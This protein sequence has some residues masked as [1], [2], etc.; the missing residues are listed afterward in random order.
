[1]KIYILPVQPRF[2]L[3]SFG[4]RYP[5]FNKDYCV[6]QD[7]LRFLLLN[8]EF[9]TNNPA[10]ADWHYLP[11]YWS[12]W[13]NFHGFRVESGFPE[14]NQEIARVMIDDSRTF[15]TC[16]YD[17]GPIVELG[18]TTQFLAVRKRNFGIDLPLIFTHHKLPFR[19]PKKKY[20]ASFQGEIRNHPLRCELLDR[21]QD[22]LDCTLNGRT[23]PVVK[24]FMNGIL[25]AYIALSPRGYGGTS[26][27][28]YEAMQ[29]GVVPY[30]IGDFDARPFKKFIPWDEFSFFSS[31]I[32]D[33]EKT[34]DKWRGK[35]RELV[36]MGRK[37]FECWQ[38]K[39]VYQKWC[40]YLIEELKL[41]N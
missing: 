8:T 35:T 4:N 25:E 26:F 7:F 19:P 10:D 28:F 20:L 36:E 3:A 37:A 1:M 31:S 33:V 5:S 2:Q 16:Q 6:E 39:L 9:L 15:T 21:L 11:V 30:F 17:D 24:E 27:R 41:L 29:F 18:K 32:D 23:T 13:H 14:L 22:R 40:P 34:L 12:R 38:E